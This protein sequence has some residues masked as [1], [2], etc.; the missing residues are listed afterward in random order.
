MERQH[1]GNF[2][3]VAYTTMMGLAVPGLVTE[4]PRLSSVAGK[5]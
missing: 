5:A 2:S 1:Y 3:V 4:H